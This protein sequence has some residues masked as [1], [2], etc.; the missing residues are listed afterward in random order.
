MVGLKNDLALFSCP[1]RSSGDTGIKLSETLCGAKSAENSAP[2]TS[3][4][5]TS[6]VR[7]VVP[8]GQHLGANQ[9]TR[10][11]A[12]DGGEM[13][14]QRSFAAGGIAVDTRDRHLREQRRGACSS[15]SVPIL[16]APDAWSRRKD[17]GAGSGA[18][19]RNGGSADGAAPVQ[20]I[21]T[22]AAR[23]F[24]YPAAIVAQQRWRKAAAV[25]KQDHWLS[26]CR[27]WRIRLISAGDRPACSGCPL[28]SSTCCWAGRALPA[29]LLKVNWRYLPGGRYAESPAPASPSRELSGSARCGRAIPPGRG[30]GS[31]SLPAACRSC[32]AL[33]R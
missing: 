23:A 4:R 18:G 5:E 30:H 12:M 29:R 31:A 26:A 11:A 19:C 9:N 21:V 27:C 33:R 7:E 22:V 15:C 24:R 28:R 1:A 13:L 25:K 20:R 6:D 16:P 17:T 10:P 2:S 8:F 14:L 32:H 3:S